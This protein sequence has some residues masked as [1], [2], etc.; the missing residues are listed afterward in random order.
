MQ[1][2]PVATAHLQRLVRQLDDAGVTARLGDVARDT[3]RANVERFDPEAIFDDSSTLGYTAARNVANRLLSDL[4]GRGGALQPRA[5]AVKEN[6]STV[7]KVGDIDVHVIKARVDRGRAPRFRTDFTWE[8]REGRV[9]AATRNFERYAAPRVVEGHEPLFNVETADAEQR[10]EACRDVFAV[11][12]GDFDGRTAGWY[13]LP[14]T[15]TGAWL[16]VSRAWF[17][18]DVTGAI[19]PAK[20][21]SPVGLDF[22]QME[23]PRPQI[24]LKPRSSEGSS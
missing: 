16:A 15:A 19:F 13:G 22:S 10:V 11:W 4:R 2:D 1:W 24:T 3:W 12:A 17:D 20:P 5:Y 9:A 23:P 14:T 8:H 21:A 7:L 6:Q 18:E